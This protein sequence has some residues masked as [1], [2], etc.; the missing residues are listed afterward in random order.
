MTQINEGIQRNQGKEMI[1]NHR[2]RDTKAHKVMT[3]KEMG[4]NQAKLS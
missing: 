3:E 4:K 1:L 2:D